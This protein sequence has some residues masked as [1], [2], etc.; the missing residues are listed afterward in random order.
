MRLILPY[1]SEEEVKQRVIA[2]IARF[3]R[4]D[5]ELL[6]VD[7]NER[8]ITHKLAEYLQ[9]E[10][11]EWHV[12]CEYN[13]LGTDVKRLSLISEVVTPF[14]TEAKTVFPDIIIHRRRKKKNLLVM[15]VKKI[16]GDDETKD[17]E[18]LEAFTQDPNYRYC[19]GL[20]LRIG[21]PIDHLELE[22]FIQGEKTGNWTED[23]RQA[24]LGVNGL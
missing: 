18:K 13:R 24:L 16:S 1:P 12:D 9:D 11:P 22:L 15:E 8:T 5:P 23:L 4:H 10:F 2:A 3:Y 21:W 19:F 7:V 6:D 20:F 14:D 17:Y